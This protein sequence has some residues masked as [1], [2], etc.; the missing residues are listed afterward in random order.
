ML[1]PRRRLAFERELPATRELP[2]AGVNVEVGVLGSVVGVPVGLLFVESGV[3]AVAVVGAVVGVVSPDTGVEGVAEG[4]V[5][6]ETAGVSATAVTGC[7][8]VGPC[9]T[10]AGGPWRPLG[11]CWRADSA[12]GAGVSGVSLGGPAIDV[13][14]FHSFEV[15]GRRRRTVVVSLPDRLLLPRRIESRRLNMSARA[16][17]RSGAERI[18]GVIAGW[19]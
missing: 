13:P 19:R 3:V 16:G 12:A 9:I 2:E 8:T 7:R 15:I 1:G 11:G 5:T 17:G 4:A 6:V 18:A 14:S 10:L